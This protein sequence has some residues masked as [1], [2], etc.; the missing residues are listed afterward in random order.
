[1]DILKVRP[2]SGTSVCSVLESMFSAKDIWIL[3]DIETLSDGNALQLGH[4]WSEVQKGPIKIATS[5]LCTALRKATQV[6]E[7]DVQLENDNARAL[8]IEDG[9]L[10]SNALG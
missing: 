8:V 3:K 5:E 9:E 1:M 10:V 6:I 2:I 4:L 7:L